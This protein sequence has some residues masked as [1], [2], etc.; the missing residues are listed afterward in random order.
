M[1]QSFETQIVYSEEFSHINSIDFVDW[2]IHLVCLQ[3]EGSFLYNDK[4]LHIKEND[5]LIILQS[6][7]ISHI[8]TNENLQV[9][10]IAASNQFLHN[11]LPNGHYGIAAS[12]IL[13]NNPT[14]SVS[15]ADAMQ[16]S[17][18]F[19]QLRDR[20]EETTHSFYNELVG[21]LTLVMVYDLYEFHSKIC[22][23]QTVSQR[24]TDLVSM[25][26][27]MLASGLTKRHRE[28]A[29]YASKLNVSPKYLSDTVRRNTGQSVTSLIDRYTIPI[30][31][32][33][34]R[35][36]SL[37]ISQIA[38]GMSFA[39]LTYFSYY[40]RKHLGMSPKAYRETKIPKAK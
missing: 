25:L 23:N 29:F 17:R 38:D 3:G 2:C 36:T 6:D 13:W 18:D 4:Y 10:F 20:L 16:L 19:H 24:N 11:Q 15:K 30:V 33:Y 5:V 28:V 1:E 14:I 37:S 9:E 21:S 35:N 8:E 32:D 22:G 40:V 27:A 26:T 7:K 31:I 39:S 34:L 12:V